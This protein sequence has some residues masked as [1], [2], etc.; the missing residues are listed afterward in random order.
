MPRSP[1]FWSRP[2]GPAAL[3][4]AP[5]GGIYA[6]AARLRQLMTRPAHAG[7]P[8]ICIGNPT[9]GGAGKTP[10]AIAVAE[11]LRD[12]GV[13]PHFLTRGYGGTIGG[14]EL[15]DLKRH[16]SAEVG[17]EP[18]LLAAHGPVHVSADRVAGATAAVAAGADVIVMDDGFQNPTLFKN[19]SFLV[20]DGEAG[21]GNGFVFPAGPLRAGLSVQISRADAVIVV[22]DG[23]AGE[24]IADSA[25]NWG[26]PV[27]HARLQPQRTAAA[28]NGH[29]VFAFSG[30]GRPAKF[31]QTLDDIG[32]KV[33]GTLNFADHHKFQP[34]DIEKIKTLADGNGAPAIVTTEKDFVRFNEDNDPDGRFRQTLRVVPV[35]MV[36]DNPGEVTRLLKQLQFSSR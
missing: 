15:V 33:V 24:T 35:Q 10:A 18:L 36:F 30:I 14:P 9:V 31:Y 4:L 27:L 28:L 20:I 32:A 6:I 17:D 12:L 8:I 1:E 34:S 25:T 19:I 2:P 11:M 5:L 3:A 7:V 16:T 21:A 23:S 22:G 13:R 29:P 26:K